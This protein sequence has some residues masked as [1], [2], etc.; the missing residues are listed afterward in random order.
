MTIGEFLSEDASA[1]VVEV[2][3]RAEDGGLNC[4]VGGGQPEHDKCMELIG[5]GKA[6]FAFFFLMTI[7]TVE[8]KESEIHFP[9]HYTIK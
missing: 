9:I 8:I 1:D 7:F 5:D 2:G 3:V 4:F 6:A